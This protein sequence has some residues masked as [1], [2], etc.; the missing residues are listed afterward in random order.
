MLY[1]EYFIIGTLPKGQPHKTKK[2]MEKKKKNLE[3]NQMQKWKQI[4]SFSSQW[5]ETVVKYM[6]D[7]HKIWG[8]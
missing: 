8:K 1:Q 2:Q 7:Y 5:M 6:L 4:V 3:M